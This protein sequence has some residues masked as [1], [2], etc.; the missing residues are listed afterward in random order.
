MRYMYIALGALFLGLLC[1]IS[2][3]VIG[4]EVAPSGLLM[5]PFWLLPMGYIFYLIGLISIIK[6]RFF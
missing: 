5:E 6:W 1:H 2:Y 3:W 4:A